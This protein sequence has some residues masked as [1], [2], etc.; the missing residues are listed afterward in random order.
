MVERKSWKIQGRDK[1]RWREEWREEGGR[2]E[3]REREQGYSR[4][5]SG[6]EEARTGV[7]GLEGGIE[8]ELRDTEKA[9]E[10]KREE[11]GGE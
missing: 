9:E 2:G 5:H 3:L 6:K 8:G 1:Q 7:I 4:G 10:V 11:R